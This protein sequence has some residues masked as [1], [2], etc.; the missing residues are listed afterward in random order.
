M[1]ATELAVV[2]GVVGLIALPHRLPLDRVSPLVAASI[3]LSALALRALAMGGSA[4]FLFVYLPRTDL[5]H[6]IKGW[7]FHAVVPF[8]ATHLGLSGHAFADAAIL[9]PG[10]AMAAS[11]LWLAAVMM[12]AF[13][14]LSLHLRRR[15]IGEGP[16]GSV[17]TDEPEFVVAAT[18]AGPARVLVSQTALE[19]MD[20]QEL[21]ASVTHELGHVRRRHRPMF[22]AGSL[23]SALARPL[24][25]TAAAKRGLGL[26]LERDADEYSVKMT[27]DPLSLASAICKAAAAQ[28]PSPALVHLGGNNGCIATR[29]ETLV[30]GDKGRGSVLGER[31]AKLLA[32]FMVAAAIALWASLPSWATAAPPH[33]SSAAT[34]SCQ[35]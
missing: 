28:H 22:L 1:V 33:T 30:D 7:C 25:G 14:L 34:Q 16:Y 9:L 6:V 21:E 18:V 13:V 11:A 24:P 35:D 8:L 3:W 12:R 23:C 4:I 17:I 19:A 15:S 10:L 5:F 2:V 27:R 32:M 20:E 31:C 29:L 26:S